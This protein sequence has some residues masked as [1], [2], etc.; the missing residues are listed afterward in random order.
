M[1]FQSLE[2]FPYVVNVILKWCRVYHS[3]VNIH[4]AEIIKLLIQN[5]I[6]FIFKRW[7]GFYL[8]LR[9]YKER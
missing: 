6:L 5:N 1:S 9:N 8:T 4:Y 7:S 3:I 2:D